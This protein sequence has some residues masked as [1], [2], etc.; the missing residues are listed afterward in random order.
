MRSPCGAGGAGGGQRPHR[1]RVDGP[2]LDVV[3]VGRRPR[4][5]EGEVPDGAVVAAHD[6]GAPALRGRDDRHGHATATSVVFA[7]QEDHPGVDVQLLARP[8]RETKA[9][10]GG[11]D[12]RHA[13]DGSGAVLRCLRLWA[14]IENETLPGRVI[15][16]G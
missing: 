13:L 11:N 2:G 9:M 3:V 10:T 14:R 8:Y 6:P 5:V 16:A 7:A 4:A 12:I 1:T 15:Y